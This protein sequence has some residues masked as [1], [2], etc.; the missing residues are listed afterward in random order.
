TP[1]RALETIGYPRL[2]AVLTADVEAISRAAPWVARLLVNG[3][4]LIVCLAY[5]AW[6]SAPLVGM[7]CVFLVLGGLSY[8]RLTS[9]GMTYVRAAHRARDTLYSHFRAVI[10]G[11]KELK[12]YRHWERRF[13]TLFTSDAEHFRDQR[14]RA[15]SLFAVTGA[16]AVTLFFLAIGFSL[17]VAPLVVTVSSTLLIQF[18]LAI[19]FML[20]PLRSMMNS[21]P[22]LAQAGVALARVTELDLVLGSNQ[23]WYEEAPS[24]DRAAE[25]GAHE[26]EA[27]SEAPFSTID[28]RGVRFQFDRLIPEQRAMIATVPMSEVRLFQAF[29]LDRDMELSVIEVRPRG[30]RR[31]TVLHTVATAH[32]ANTPVLTRA[33]LNR[34]SSP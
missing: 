28:L 14:V 24:E 21:L 9:R 12:L 13:S 34:N 32:A 30:T 7:L 19:L 33:G 29:L 1:Q 4:I 25:D 23:D 15:T 27:E 3:A 16:W 17:F 11:S 5:M 22:E 31:Q 20:T 2:L 26:D 18:A 6:L 8:Y 10:E